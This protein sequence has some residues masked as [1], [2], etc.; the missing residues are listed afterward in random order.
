MTLF[1]ANGQART[2]NYQAGDVGMCRMEFLL[3]P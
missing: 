3:K 1:A 2:F